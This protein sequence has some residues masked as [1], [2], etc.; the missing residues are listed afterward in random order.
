MFEICHCHNSSVNA[1][2]HFSAIFL[3]RK[4]I[5]VVLRRNKWWSL[6]QYWGLLCLHIYYTLDCTVVLSV[7]WVLID[8]L[9][10]L[11]I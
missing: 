8:L 3:I 10:V 2:A 7:A 4:W 6:G 1:H 5:C 11:F 9:T